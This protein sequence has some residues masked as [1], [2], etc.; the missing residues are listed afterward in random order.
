MEYKKLPEHIAII[1][2]GNGRWAKQ[3]G[4]P[5]NEGHRK[6]TKTLENIIKHADKLGIKYL[7]VYAFSTENWKRPKDEVDGLM[8][9]FEKYLD[10]STKKAKKNNQKF[11]VLGDIQ[12]SI[13]PE[14]IR[15]KI[16][17]L[18]EITKDHSGICFNMAFNYGGRN[19]VIRACK[20]IIEDIVDNKA[21]ISGLSE[22]LMSEYLDTKG[23]PDPDLMIRTSG[24]IRTSNFLPWQLTY[25]EFYFAECMW[26]EF[27]EKEF[28][29][30]IKVFGE[31]QRRFG[32]SE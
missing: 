6:G 30:A 20:H 9:L 12:A 31:R 24:E 5:R 19:E 10:D 18:E 15:V 17:K 13:V 21:D 27:D 8:R 29:N 26:P 1:M 23:M 7:T 2:D 4:L 16:E 25:S 11:R 28:D 22:D 32:K 3:K 14:H